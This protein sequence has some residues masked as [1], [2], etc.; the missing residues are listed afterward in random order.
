MEGPKF[1]HLILSFDDTR[2]AA[3]FHFDQVKTVEKVLERYS[4]ALMASSPMQRTYIFLSRKEL[5]KESPRHG[6]TRHVIEPLRNLRLL[7][8]STAEIPLKK[9]T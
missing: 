5:E 4:V 3:K 1:F 6:R 9:N 2:M 8:E 7:G